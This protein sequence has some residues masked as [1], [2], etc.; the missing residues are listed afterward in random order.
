[1]PKQRREVDAF[2]RL[3]QPVLAT[4]LVVCLGH[5]DCRY[6]EAGHQGFGPVSQSVCHSF[7]RITV[8]CSMH[9]ASPYDPQDHRVRRHNPPLNR[10]M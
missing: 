7:L 5:R 6:D 2:Q 4:D 3:M 1:M 9:D 8:R 10:Q